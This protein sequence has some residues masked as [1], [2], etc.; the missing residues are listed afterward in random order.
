MLD[1]PSFLVILLFV[2]F[3]FCNFMLSFVIPLS[4]SFF[5]SSR[6]PLIFIAF[7]FSPSPHP[8]LL[9]S[10]LLLLPLYLILHLFIHL[11][12][13]PSSSFI[14]SPHLP[15]LPFP[16]DLSP[17]SSPSTHSPLLSPPPFSFSY[18]Y[19]C[20]R[21]LNGLIILVLFSSSHSL[22]ALLPFAFPLTFLNNY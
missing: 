7:L 11:S 9:I 1:F 5:T 19:F 6:F 4:L 2:Y 18:S 10:P 14:S 3:C 16:F 13:F 8:Y 12:L 20:S 22:I 17:H 21:C 15:P